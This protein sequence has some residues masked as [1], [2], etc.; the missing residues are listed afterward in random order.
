LGPSFFLP[1]LASFLG[2]IA[3]RG[4]ALARGAAAAEHAARRAAA[5]AVRL[6]PLRRSDRSGRRRSHAPA[7]RRARALRSA[8]AARPLDRRRERRRRLGRGGGAPLPPAGRSRRAAAASATAAALACSGGEGKRPSRREK[9]GGE[10]W[11]RRPLAPLRAPHG[12]LVLAQMAASSRMILGGA[13]GVRAP[14]HARRGR[15]Q[16]LGP[17]AG[18]SRPAAR[19]PSAR[20]RWS[21]GHG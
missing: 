7:H 1:P 5:C 2:A 8:C 21:V 14:S 19:P 6:A 18:H 4:A 3:A 15:P 10:R 17:T 9:W 11:A 12:E 20:C 16:V 13:A